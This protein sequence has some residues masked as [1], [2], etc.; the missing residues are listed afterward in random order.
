M[1][2]KTPEEVLTEALNNAWL[3]GEFGADTLDDAKAILAAM[4]DYTIVR[5]NEMERLR[6][7]VAAARAVMGPDEDVPP[8]EEWAAEFVALR[9]ALRMLDKE[10]ADGE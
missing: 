8:E 2:D 6:A 1:T 9:D 4:P 10:S 5:K 7:V 3:E